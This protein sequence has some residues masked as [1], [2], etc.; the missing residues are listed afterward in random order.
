MVLLV[1]LHILHLF[2]S[3]LLRRQYNDSADGHDRKK[4]SIIDED[5]L[6]ILVKT[7]SDD[8]Y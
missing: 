4:M 1:S 3:K 5:R 8:Y 7:R 2:P 6:I